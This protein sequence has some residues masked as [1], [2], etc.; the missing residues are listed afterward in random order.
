M[1]QTAAEPL[2][3]L[4]QS[5]SRLIIPHGGRARGVQSSETVVELD[6]DKHK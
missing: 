1:G 5:G 3:D 2:A 4:R 6:L